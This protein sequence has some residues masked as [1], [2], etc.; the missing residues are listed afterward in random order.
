MPDTSGVAFISCS[1][2]V[3]VMPTV[4]R[5]RPEDSTHAAPAPGHATSS[6]KAD[7]RYRRTTPPNAPPPGAQADTPATARPR[8]QGAQAGTV[9]IVQQMSG[10]MMPRPR[11]ACRQPRTDDRLAAVSPCIERSRW[12]HKFRRSRSG[13]QCTCTGRGHC[14]IAALAANR[15]RPC[16]F[17]PKES[18]ARP[19]SRYYTAISAL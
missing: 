2:K 9:I 13:Q 12:G 8:Y 14:R 15:L 5:T 10:I 17:R 18:V 4:E 16:G 11:F 3:L 1:S 6:R 7:N 19:S